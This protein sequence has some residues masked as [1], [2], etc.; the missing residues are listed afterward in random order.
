MGAPFIT[1]TSEGCKKSAV[2]M[3]QSRDIVDGIIAGMI[4]LADN[5]PFYADSASAFRKAIDDW[6]TKARII[7]ADLTKM[8]WALTLTGNNFDETEFSNQSLGTFY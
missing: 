4:D 8:S 3:A 6:A 7:S 2:E 1:T 5:M